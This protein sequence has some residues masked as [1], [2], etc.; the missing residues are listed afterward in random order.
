[1]CGAEDTKVVDSRLAGAGD[2]V[3]RRRRC[4]ECSYRFTT[5]ERVDEVPLVVIKSDGTRQP[6]DRAKV[7]AGIRA[8]CKGRGVST[9]DVEAI[10]DEVEDLLRAEATRSETGAVSS[11]AIGLAVLE[12]LRV[13]DDVA[14]LRFASVYKNFD[15]ASDFHRELELLDK[16]SAES[17]SG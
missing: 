9:G 5:F 8:A 4:E 12:R 15:A 6:F 7:T 14:Y 10:G 3:R 1:M 13:L 2:A 17:S 11:A 16:L